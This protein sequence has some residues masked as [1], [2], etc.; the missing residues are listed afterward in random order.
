VLWCRSPAR[1]RD[2]F[3]LTPDYLQTPEQASTQLMDYGLALGRRLR[4]LKLWFVLRWFG[5]D[6]IAARLRAHV[7]LAAT[8]AGWV[9]DD[10]GFERLAPA[11]FSVVVFRS[12]PAGLSEEALDRHNAAVLE[13]V[14]G[15]GE[16]YL[17]HTKVRGRYAIRLAI[18]NLR[19]TE[20]HVRRAWELLCAAGAADTASVQD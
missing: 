2:A 13:A 7:R 17:S 15:S 12:V 6:G 3:S 4:A 8:F 10:A 9:D 11:H 20:R 16:V 18:G 5:A 14:N 19:T 1:L